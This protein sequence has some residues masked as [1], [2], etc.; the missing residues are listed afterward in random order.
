MKKIKIAIVGC[1]GRMG[2]QIVKEIKNFKDISL[3]AAIEKKILLILIK[4]LIKL[5]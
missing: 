1:S 2:K 4:K 5:K 3:A